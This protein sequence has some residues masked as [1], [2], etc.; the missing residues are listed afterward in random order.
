MH[1]FS[2]VC[3]KEQFRESKFS[4]VSTNN[5]EPALGHHSHLEGIAGVPTP[6]TAEAYEVQYIRAL[7]WAAGNPKRAGSSG[8]ATFHGL[9]VHLCVRLWLWLY[10]AP[11]GAVT[12]TAAAAGPGRA[13]STAAA[14]TAGG[15]FPPPLQFSF[16]FKADFIEVVVN[17]WKVIFPD[18]EWRLTFFSSL[19]SVLNRETRHYCSPFKSCIIN[20]VII[21][22]AYLLLTTIVWCS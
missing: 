2:P 5:A 14:Q 15:A 12:V 22:L 3:L 4:A 16:L 18:V 9:R 21:L 10:P 8:S 6:R 13:F 11:A 1:L 19:C 20:T 7:G 17:T